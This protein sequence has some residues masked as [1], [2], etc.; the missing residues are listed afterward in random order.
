VIC[1]ERLT[2]SPGDPDSPALDRAAAIIRRG[3]IVAF[4]TDTYYGVAA[5]PRSIEGVRRVFAAKGRDE[6]QPL[7]LIAA[8][9]AQVAAASDDLP[10]LALR[11]ADRFWPGPLTLVVAAAAC[12]LP[13]VHAN[14]GTVGIRVPDHA[15]A[16][17]LAA[18]SGFAIVSTSANLSGSPAV[19]TAEEVIAGIG[20]AVDLVL[21][22]GPTAG[23]APSTIVDARGG[24]PTLIREGAIL[25]SL[26]LEAT[27]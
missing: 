26:V 9:R 22:A 5:D 6:H 11:L 4:P 21:D 12:I 24:V 15:V 20:H 3:G 14:T 17:A 13:G 16:R 8:D 18:R 25:F 27:S 10:P 23:G 19:S 2:I 1:V 7:P